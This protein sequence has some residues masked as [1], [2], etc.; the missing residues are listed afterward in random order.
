MIKFEEVSLPFR[1]TPSKTVSGSVNGKFF[2]CPKD[3]ESEITL[4][5]FV[6][7]VYSA[8]KEELWK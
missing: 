8:N 6:A 5:V 3:R 7:I 1:F 4:E 2:V